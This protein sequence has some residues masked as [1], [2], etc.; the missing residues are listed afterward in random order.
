MRS[1]ESKERQRSSTASELGTSYN[2]DSQPVYPVFQQKDKTS[3]T[4]K[5]KHVTKTSSL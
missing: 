5:V 3:K 1:N 4:E 2:I